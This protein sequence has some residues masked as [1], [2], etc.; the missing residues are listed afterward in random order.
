MG[1]DTA[2]SHQ[3]PMTRGYQNFK[4]LIY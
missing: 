2:L 1:R 3:Q 4:I